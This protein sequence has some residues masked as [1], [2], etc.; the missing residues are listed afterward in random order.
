MRLPLLAAA[1]LL[2]AGCSAPPPSPGDGGGPLVVRAVGGGTSNV[3][4]PAEVR[5]EPGGAVRWV[6]DSGHHTV[7]F[8]RDVNGNG[9]APDS[10]DLGPGQSYELA[11]PRA[12]SYR[13]RCIYHSSGFGASEGMVGVVS[14]A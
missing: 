14:V 8:E 10:G 12:G 7:T 9:T 1:A 2:L 11:L 6:G 3:F 4:E 13:Y 5:V